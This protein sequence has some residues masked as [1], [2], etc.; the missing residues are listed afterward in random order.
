MIFTRLDFA[1]R[2]VNKGLRGH[3]R[4]VPDAYDHWQGKSSYYI[5]IRVM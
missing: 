5:G 2:G 1:V 3:R 4:Y